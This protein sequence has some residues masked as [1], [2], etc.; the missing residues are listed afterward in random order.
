M[1]EAKCLS[2]FAYMM[3]GLRSPW[4]MQDAKVM[5]KITENINF[6]KYFNKIQMKT[7]NWCITNILR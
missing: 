2:T 4:V 1:G 7:E 3:G 6:K 5:K